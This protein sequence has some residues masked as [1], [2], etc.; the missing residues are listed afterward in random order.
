MA[1]LLG[2]KAVGTDRTQSAS[3][4]KERYSGQPLSPIPAYKPKSLPGQVER[5]DGLSRNRGLCQMHKPAP[6]ARRSRLESPVNR[7]AVRGAGHR[8]RD[9]HR[10]IAVR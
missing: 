8:G 9:N 2:G 10:G 5:C 3:S 4:G 7:R 1:H 6:A